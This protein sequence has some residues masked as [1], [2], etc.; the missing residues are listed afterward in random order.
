LIARFF[1]AAEMPLQFDVNIFIPKLSAEILHAL[2][3]FAHSSAGQRV[4]QRAFVASGKANQSGGVFG[5][6]FGGNVAFSFA[7]AQFHARDQPAEILVSR[8]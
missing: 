8:A 7:R 6:F 1:L 2:Q 4:G 3:P 5:D